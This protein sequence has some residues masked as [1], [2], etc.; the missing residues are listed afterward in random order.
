M[1]TF[2]IHS[3]RRSLARREAHTPQQAVTDYLRAL[4]CTAGEMVIVSP[5]SMAWRGSIFTAVPLSDLSRS[6]AG[7]DAHSS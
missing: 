7:D 6:E 5:D 1:K 4:G 2:E 3:G